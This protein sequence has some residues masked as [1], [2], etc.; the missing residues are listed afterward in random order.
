MSSA[1]R[2][3]SGLRSEDVLLMPEPVYFGGTVD[4]AI[5]SDEIVGEVGD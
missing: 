1:L 4:R 3:Q 2:G 5:G